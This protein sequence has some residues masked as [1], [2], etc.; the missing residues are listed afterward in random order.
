MVYLNSRL[1]RNS[2]DRGSKKYD[3]R[4]NIENSTVY[5]HYDITLASQSGMERLPFVPYLLK[6]WRGPFSVC[7][8]VYDNNR[9]TFET[10][11]STYYLPSRFSFST[12]YTSNVT[13]YPI[14]TLRNIAIRKVKT[15]HF[16]LTD[17]DMW[18]SSDLYEILLSL[19]NSYLQ[20]TNAAIIIPAFQMKRNITCHSFE[21]C[22]AQNFINAPSSKPE[23][24][25][26]I[27]KKECI[28]INKK[29]NH[30]YMR[31]QW[32]S[33]DLPPVY[34]L[35][36]MV[37]D[38]QEPYVVVKKSQFLPLFDERFINYGYNKQQWISHLRM[39]GYW[40]YV[41]N[42]GYAM[43]VYHDPSI[44]ESR[45]HDASS[46]NQYEVT[47]Y[48]LWKKF[49]ARTSLQYEHTTSMPTC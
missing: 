10:I 31:P 20:N 43:N 45:W 25:T 30:N 33:L 24:L 47:H 9:T 38:Y 23:L 6:L 39:A 40:F 41:L 2:E 49:L 35:A 19:S 22:A 17:I 12:Y 18:P 21:A 48:A 46:R 32:Y 37:N 28:P 8:F 11:L 3:M 29:G 7:F 14:N 4:V 36:C 44:Y 42:G 26:C 5:D 34:P 27:Q 16:W 1:P 15:S 13:I